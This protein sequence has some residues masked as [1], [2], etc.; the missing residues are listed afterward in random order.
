MEWYYTKQDSQDRESN[1]GPG[2]SL[3]LLQN[4]QISARKRC[5]APVRCLARVCNLVT[6]SHNFKR[7]KGA[8][9]AIE[10]KR[11]ER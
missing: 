3:R 10:R 5:D 1:D 2:F 4:S 7:G 11:E 8:R 9:S 6:F